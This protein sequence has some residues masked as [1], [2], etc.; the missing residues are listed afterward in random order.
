MGLVRVPENA[1]HPLDLH[2]TGQL[3]VGLG[4]VGAQCLKVIGGEVIHEPVPAEYREHTLTGLVLVTESPQ[5]QLAGIDS[6]LLGDEESVDQIKLSV[7]QAYRD[8]SETAE[9][10]RIQKV[11]LELA[12]KR[13]DREKLLLEY[14]QGTVRLLLE[15]EDAIVSA[16][17][18]V[19]TAL[20][21]HMVTKL[22]F[23]RDIGVLQVKPDGM[24]EQGKEL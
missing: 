5:G 24:W 15:S 19:T 11:G 4:D 23:F 18:S 2:L 1:P 22:N 6:R 8:L 12:L 9:S 10:Y 7:R 20:V 21:N 14:G 13:L 3:A 16:Q 17:N